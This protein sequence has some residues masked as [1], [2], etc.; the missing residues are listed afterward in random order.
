[1]VSLMQEIKTETL[2][3]YFK[4]ISKPPTIRNARVIGC[5]CIEGEGEALYILDHIYHVLAGNE[6]VGSSDR[7][8]TVCGQN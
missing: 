2:N 7:Y 4:Q 6:V 8:R 5:W 1:M 3:I